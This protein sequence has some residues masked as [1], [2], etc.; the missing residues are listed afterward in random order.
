MKYFIMLGVFA[1]VALYYTLP[2]LVIVYVMIK[3]W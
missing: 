3:E 1:A 2:V